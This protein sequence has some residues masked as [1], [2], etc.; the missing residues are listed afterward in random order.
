LSNA[1][2]VD[3]H[4]KPVTDRENMRSAGDFGVQLILTPSEKEFVQTWNTSSSPPKL[5]VANSVRRGSSVSA[6]LIFQGCTPN[7]SGKFDV[8]TEFALVAPDGTR[9][10]WGGGP[11]CTAEPVRGKLQ[12]GNAS[13]TVN[14]DATDAVGM[15]KLLATVK[16]KVSGTTLDLTRPLQVE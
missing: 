1:G 8:V 2:W 5:R 4:G 14:F 11:V 7:A 15:Y 9:T 10:P 13:M 16:D 6:I 12:L 3:E